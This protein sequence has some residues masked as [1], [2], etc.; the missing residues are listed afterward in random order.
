MKLN[1]LIKELL[2]IHTKILTIIGTKTLSRDVQLSA[3]DT[4]NMIEV[5]LRVNNH[6]HW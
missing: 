5:L 1:K 6:D 2:S 3:Y 4:L